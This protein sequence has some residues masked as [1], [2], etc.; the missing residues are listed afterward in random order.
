MIRR[1]RLSLKPNVRPG[2]RAAAPGNASGGRDGGS[3]PP[4]EPEPGTESKTAGPGETGAAQPR[5]EI[6]AEEID[7]LTT[8]NNEAPP[9]K[10]AP[11]LPQRRKRIS[12]LPNLAKPR[13]SNAAPTV[14]PSPKPPQV[15]VPTPVPIITPPMQQVT[16]PEKRTPVPQVPQFSPFKKAVLKPQDVSPVKP[17]EELSPL[18]ERPSQISFSIDTFEVIKRTAPKKMVTGNLER[19]RIRRAQKLRDL[20]KAELRKERKSSKEKNAAIHPL[21]VLE[22]SKMTM[23]DFIHFIPLSNPM[24]SSLEENKCIEKSPPAEPQVTR[25]GGKNSADEDDHGDED[26]EEE[27]DSQLLAP[28]VKVAEDGSIILD[29]ESLTVE[30][31]RNKAPIVEGNDPIFERGSTTTYTSFRRSS[32]S[33]PWSQEETDMF[34]LA[35]SMVGTDF[36]M[37]GQLFPHRERIEIKNKFKREE[38]LNGWRIDKAFRE[39]KDFDFECFAKLLEKA[40]EAGK[41]K[42]ARVRQPRK[43]HTNA[44]S[45][46]KQKDQASAEQSLCDEE[47]SLLEEDG[48]D[49]GTAEKENKRSPDVDECSE[50]AD[51]VPAKKKR[52]K[53]KKETAKEP[54]ESQDDDVTKMS[55]KKSKNKT[56]ALEPDGEPELQPADGDGSLK[57]TPEKNLRIQTNLQNYKESEMEDDENDADFDVTED[58]EVEDALVSCKAGEADI[59]SQ[60][61]AMTCEKEN[62]LVLFSEESDYHSGLD[63]LSSLH[64]SLNEVNNTISQAPDVSLVAHNLPGEI[65][66]ALGD[67]TIPACDQV[68]ASDKAAESDECGKQDSNSTDKQKMPVGRRARPV[69]NLS[70][71][72]VKKKVST[73]EQS[74]AK[75]Q[76]ESSVDIEAGKSGKER[77][78]ENNLILDQQGQGDESAKDE[79]DS[80]TPHNGQKESSLKPML[81][82]RGRFQRPKPNLPGRTLTRREKSD[83]TGAKDVPMEETGISNVQ[84]EDTENLIT[85]ETTVSSTVDE[86]RQ[87]PGAINGDT[88]AE[89]ELSQVEAS[90]TEQQDCEI[91]DAGKEKP[92]LPMRG[93]LRPKPNLTRAA[94]KNKSSDTEQDSKQPQSSSQVS[95]ACT[96][97]L[98]TAA[99]KDQ[100]KAEERTESW[101]G[102]KDE[103]GKSPIKPAALGRGRLQRPKPNLTKASAK[104]EASDDKRE[105][106]GQGD[107]G[108]EEDAGRDYGCGEEET[109][110]S[111]NNGSGSSENSCNSDIALCPSSSKV[112]QDSSVNRDHLSEASGTLETCPKSP[113]K[114]TQLPP[115]RLPKPKPNLSRASRRKG[116]FTTKDD[117]SFQAASGTVEK[118]SSD[119]LNSSSCVENIP[120]NETETTAP[121]LSNSNKGSSVA[122]D[123]VSP[124]KPDSETS[125]PVDCT[126]VQTDKESR[127][128]DDEKKTS[129]PILTRGRF[130]RPKPNLTKSS[131][132]SSVTPP[133]V[134]AAPEE[135]RLGTTT[136]DNN[137]QNISMDGK[138]PSHENPEIKSSPVEDTCDKVAAVETLAQPHKA[139]SDTEGAD[140]GSV[141]PIRNRFSKPSPNIGRAAV[142]KET[143]TTECKTLLPEKVEETSKEL[144]D[145]ED[146]PDTSTAD[147]GCKD[148]GHS[149]EEKSAAIKPVQ[150]KR[151]RLVRPVPNLVKAMTSSPMP[152]KVNL[153]TLRKKDTDNVLANTSPISKRK[154]SDFGTCVSPKRSCPPGSPQKPSRLSES[155]VDPAT[156]NSE[157]PSS[158]PSSSVQEAATQ[159]SR[160]GRSLRKLSTEPSASPKSENSSEKI[161]RVVK[162]TTSK[163]SKLMSSKNKGKTP[164]VKIRATQPEDEDE[165][166]ADLGFEEEDYD[167]APDVQNQA[168]VFI[169]F[170]LRSPKPVAAEIE[171]TVEELEIPVDVVDLPNGT[172]QDLGRNLQDATDPQYVENNKEQRDGSAEAAMTLISMGRPVYKPE[173]TGEFSGPDQC[174]ETGRQEQAISCHDG[175]DNRIVEDPPNIGN[176]TQSHGIDT[177]FGSAEILSN[178]LNDNLVF[179]IEQISYPVVQEDSLQQGFTSQDVSIS[180]CLLGDQDPGEETTF[181]L[182]LV[183]IPITDD[184]AYPCD[185]SMAESLPAP[186]LISSGS[187]QSLT[188]NLHPSAE[189]ASYESCIDGQD[190]KDLLD[191]TPKQRNSLGMDEGDNSP[192][193]EK[194]IILE[195][196]HVEVKDGDVEEKS[197]AKLSPEVTVPVHKP[198]ESSDVREGPSNMSAAK[199]SP[200]PMEMPGI[201][202]MDVLNRNLPL[203]YAN[204]LISSKT[205]LKRPGK[206][207]LG[208]LSLVCKEKQAKKVG[209]ENRKKKNLPQLKGR[210]ISPTVR[211]HQKESPDLNLENLHDS[212]VPSASPM[213][214]PPDVPTTATEEDLPSVSQT[215][216]NQDTEQ[217]MAPKSPDLTTEEEAAPVSEYFFSDIFMEVDD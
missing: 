118:K 89:S 120:V 47:L 153:G 50:V 142:R 54:Q 57:E 202:Q 96:K 74:E 160:F 35:I 135:K 11:A 146:V 107:G 39:K 79:E 65:N 133:A 29:E 70:R 210:K 174:T 78:Q 95:D 94:A 109:L 63:D 128:S 14:V 60:S 68:D 22:K 167:L 132:R 198:E 40:L 2:G 216:D 141:K 13:V 28:R 100:E 126:T 197:A 26:D 200:V 49:A 23:R 59:S 150:L 165:D 105:S 190:D 113:S 163:A 137:G 19:E 161:P 176:Q 33:K 104:K 84:K 18:K 208:F 37:I 189:T 138:V 166:D 159:R 205:T 186:V 15:D 131:T 90:S 149:I 82:G 9:S 154:A 85:A 123:S 203:V 114:T 144:T 195:Q 43:T 10:T 7:T 177:D 21:V 164:L 217:Q 143:S 115:G 185:S 86:Q 71:A 181:I 121:S 171:E 183:E 193:E 156:L 62:S 48:A 211:G 16:L 206:K 64:F 125:S 75:L 191:Q 184:Y 169:P 77:L 111:V 4:A 145:V 112:T 58:F 24:S 168:P 97:P 209:E 20:L 87:E 157:A 101:S 179:P 140:A 158:S 52:T 31:S 67:A 129:R 41:K 122:E 76:A 3:A 213:L 36:S 45:R 61:I 42:K 178:P 119:D 32:Y 173:D 188:Q 56:I 204:P 201:S 151:G 55:K 182:T 38:R 81:P 147:H 116:E 175:E 102:S 8:V 53:R 44:K 139:T 98:S 187:S 108:A 155:E 6:R 93:R 46:K 69:P 34:F 180:D 148:T 124:Q 199:P 162:S 80:S 99:D 136:S 83:V 117:E 30:V 17:V 127:A 130:Q 170:S 152:S 212:E 27:D 72:A 5:E 207:P 106:S 134:S 92:S 51:P 91:G 172:N 12:T 25:L 110:A 214:S 103:G 194:P 66:V 215:C 73:E 1:A 196:V 88:G 192:L